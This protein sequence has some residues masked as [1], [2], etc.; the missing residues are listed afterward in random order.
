MFTPDAF[1]VNTQNEK[2]DNKPENRFNI[3]SDVLNQGISDNRRPC[4]NGYFLTGLVI[5]KCFIRYH[6]TITTHFNLST[7][8]SWFY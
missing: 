1:R 7:D 5:D 2:L 4:S 6:N 3:Q 8:E